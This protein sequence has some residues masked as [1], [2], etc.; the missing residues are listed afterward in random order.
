MILCQQQKHLR[1]RLRSKRRLT[2]V[3]RQALQ[4]RRSRFRASNRPRIR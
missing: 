3:L 4:K 2:A 1:L